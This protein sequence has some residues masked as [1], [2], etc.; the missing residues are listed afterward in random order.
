M[1]PIVIHYNTLLLSPEVTSCRSRESSYS[2]S[3]YHGVSCDQGEKDAIFKLYDTSQKVVNRICEAEG[4]NET[5][6]SIPQKDIKTP[7]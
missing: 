1:Y 6:L 4:V 2:C 7:S 3:L 5:E